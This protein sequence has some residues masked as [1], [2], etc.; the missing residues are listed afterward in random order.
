MPAFLPDGRW[1]NGREWVNPLA[2][3]TRRPVIPTWL[4]LWMSLWFV[5]IVVPWFVVAPHANG[6]GQVPAERLFII[7]AVDGLAIVVTGIAVGIKRVGWYAK[8]VVVAI[9]SVASLIGLFIWNDAPSK[10]QADGG[11]GAA[12]GVLVLAIPTVLG[13]A[14]IMGLGLCIGIVVRR[15]IHPRGSDAPQL[16]AG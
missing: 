14:S 16:G 6:K 10:G 1:W 2:R 5:A 12:I 9:G 7:L 8:G 4:W 13:V 11:P 3:Q 15:L